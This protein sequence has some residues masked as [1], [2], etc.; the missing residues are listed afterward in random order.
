MNT[1]SFDYNQVNIS[2]NAQTYIP[3]YHCVITEGKDDYDNV[4]I[5]LSSYFDINDSAFAIT[6][7]DMNVGDVK[8]LVTNGYIQ[9]LTWYWNYP[10]FTSLYVGGAGELTTYTLNPYSSQKVGYVVNVNTIFINIQ[11]KILFTNFSPYVS[12]T[13]SPSISPTPTPTTTPS[14]TFSPTFTP[15]ATITPTIT[16][17]PTPTLTPTNT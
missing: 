16:F 7:E 13:V 12:P 2:G 11:E 8:Q 9:D 4:L 15:S 14:I 5:S 17:T 6:T 10:A 1:V 3:R